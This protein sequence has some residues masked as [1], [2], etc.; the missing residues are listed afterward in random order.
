[1]AADH[2]GDLDHPYQGPREVGNAAGPG[3]RAGGS[4]GILALTASA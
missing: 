1:M 4:G 2:H 3:D